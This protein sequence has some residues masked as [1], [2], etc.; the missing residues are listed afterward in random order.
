MATSG[1]PLDD[2]TKRQ[3]ERMAKVASI[4]A[5][6]RELDVSRNTVRK[7]VRNLPSKVTHPLG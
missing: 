4:R 6:A 2:F 5:T 7:I 3:I 1:K